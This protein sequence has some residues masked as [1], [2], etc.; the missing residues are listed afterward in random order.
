MKRQSKKERIQSYAISAPIPVYSR[1]RISCRR[2]EVRR[3]E[4]AN[5]IESKQ[6]LAIPILP[7]RSGSI[8]RPLSIS[9]RAMIYPWEPPRERGRFRS[10]SHRLQ[11]R[12]SE[13]G[14]RVLRTLLS[15]SCM[16]ELDS[17][18]DERWVYRGIPRPSNLARPQSEEN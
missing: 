15:T 6:Y 13:E 5:L 9:P 3:W 16:Y 1:S 8:C 14:C 10:L 11:V 4:H 12:H 17:S 2:G 18:V 7:R